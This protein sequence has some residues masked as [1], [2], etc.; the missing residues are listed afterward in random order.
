VSEPDQP[1]CDWDDLDEDRQTALRVEFGHWLDALPPTCSLETKVARFR[2]WL[3][4]RGIEYR[5]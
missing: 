1:L 3:G 2:A 5:G 4:E